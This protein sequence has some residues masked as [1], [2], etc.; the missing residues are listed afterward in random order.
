M[1]TFGNTATPS[2]GS[3]FD[4]S[5]NSQYGSVIGGSFPGG[6]ITDINV[7]LAGHG[8]S[9]TVKYAIWGT[10]GSLLW[11]S[12]T[13][14]IDTTVQW[15][16]NGVSGPEG[17]GL[18]LPSGTN[19]RLGF[20]TPDNV[21]WIFESSGSIQFDRG[22]SNVADFQNDGTENTTNALGV[23]LTYI[24]VSAPTISSVTPAIGTSGSVIAL[25]GSDF[26]YTTGVTVNGAAASFTVVDDTHMNV[27][28]PAGATA[29]AGS[30]V[31]TNDAGSASHSFTVGQIYYGTGAA[32]A[33]IK[34]IWYGTGAGVAK[35]AG[36]WV[37]D[38]AGGVKRIW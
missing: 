17:P 23:Y 37:P 28:V 34:D 16:N 31:V 30:I 10:G 3:F 9:A 24:P 38:G 21:Q 18:F 27:T 19:L 15:R 26:T 4:D 36:V 14:S 12:A 13:H 22:R 7:Y 5:G 8:S 6:Y 35:I 11:N 33:S 20:W 25:V 29:G 2:S 32:V 1:A